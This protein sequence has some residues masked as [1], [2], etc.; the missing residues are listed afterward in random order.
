MKYASATLAGFALCLA[1]HATAHPLATPTP[2]QVSATLVDLD[3]RLD[4]A[5]ADLNTKWMNGTITD[6]EFQIIT[7]LLIQVQEG[8]KTFYP[9][10]GTIR[11]R[12]QAAIDDLKARATKSAQNAA[13]VDA[14]WEQLI[15]SRV[16]RHIALLL[17][18][19]KLS[20]PLT[21]EDW[22]AMFGHL[23]KRA[24]AAKDD[25]EAGDVRARLQAMIEA[26]QRKA[27]TAALTAD[28]FKPFEAELAEERV[29]RT[30]V[31]VKTHAAGKMA[32][33]LDFARVGDA[34]RD[35]GAVNATAANVM[36]AYQ[37]QIDRLE[38]AV[39]NDTL[40]AD[41][42][43]KFMLLLNVRVRGALK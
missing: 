38:A 11:T 13:L 22:S 29:H 15:D 21:R 7:D 30:V 19:I 17:S 25:A 42:F 24:Q 35:R 5:W 26:L 39:G 8:S 36:Q 16:T 3:A 23:Y 33:H 32:T 20:Q 37:E 2:V 6:R 4:A 28:D 27:A 9:E 1:S 40:T 41:Q 18:T 34:V 12:L 31:W 14:A 43:Q 10:A